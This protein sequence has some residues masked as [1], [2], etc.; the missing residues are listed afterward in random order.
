MIEVRCQDCGLSQYFGNASLDE[1]DKQI[2][3]GEVKCLECDHS[4]SVTCLCA[5]KKP[6]LI[7]VEVK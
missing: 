3:R 4:H 1:V 2:E 7:A 6:T 5:N